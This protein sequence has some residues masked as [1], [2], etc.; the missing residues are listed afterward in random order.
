MREKDREK[1]FNPKTETEECE[2]SDETS[3]DLF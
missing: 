2:R 1:I 3:D